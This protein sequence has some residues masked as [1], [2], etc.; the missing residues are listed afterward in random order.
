MTNYNLYI[1]EKLRKINF[2]INNK[3][4]YISNKVFQIKSLQVNKEMLL[5]DSFILFL[6]LCASML[7]RNQN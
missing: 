4:F 2:N 7:G 5:I 1:L 3:K 6:C